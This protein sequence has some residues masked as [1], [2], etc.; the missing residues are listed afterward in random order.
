MPRCPKGM[1]KDVNKKCVPKYSKTRKNC[2]KGQRRNSSGECVKKDE[3]ITTRKRC[4]K[5]MTKDD[6]GDCVEKKTKPKAPKKTVKTKESTESEEWNSAVEKEFDEILNELRQGK[7][8]K[9]NFGNEIVLDCNSCLK[10]FSTTELENELNSRK[11]SEQH[12]H[13]LIP[14]KK[15]PKN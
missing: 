1:V 14:R 9:A 10:K 11:Q 15:V 13:T 12:I 5:G 8:K 2:P 7:L 6:N 4:P 3:K